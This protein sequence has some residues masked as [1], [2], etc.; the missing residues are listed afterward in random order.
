[1]GLD[2]DV[3]VIVDP[4]LERGS[5]WAFEEREQQNV[6]APRVAPVE[7]HHLGLVLHVA[8]VRPDPVGGPPDLEPE[9]AHEPYAPQLPN[10]HHVAA[11]GVV[12]LEAH[13]AAHR[14]VLGLVVG[15]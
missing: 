1:A 9:N 10:W 8:A 3:H 15:A 13:E 6:G 12:G 7:D 11:T 4:G 5:E 2:A 14:G